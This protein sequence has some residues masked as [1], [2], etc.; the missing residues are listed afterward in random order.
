MYRPHRRTS[1]SSKQG[2]RCLSCA[3]RLRGRLL[4]TAS[5]NS[6]IGMDH[7]AFAVEKR[8]ELDRLVESLRAAEVDTA[9]VEVEGALNLNKEY[10]CF[11]DPDNVQ[12]EFFMV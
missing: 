12:L 8:A 3:H 2:S 9:G 7:L 4:T 11:R 1:T 6:I 10:V 5:A